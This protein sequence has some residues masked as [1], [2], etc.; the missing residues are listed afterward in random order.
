[1]Q[2]NPTGNNPGTRVGA[3]RCKPYKNSKKGCDLVKVRRCKE[4]NLDCTGETDIIVKPIR[5]EIRA[6]LATRGERKYNY[7]DDKEALRLATEEALKV[8]G[9]PRAPPSVPAERLEA[10]PSVSGPHQNSQT[11]RCSREEMMKDRP[12]ENPQV[13]YAV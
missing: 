5:T 9:Q 2:S 8:A 10:I 6:E 11:G 4:K 13:Q 3:T 12:G 1:M 7:S